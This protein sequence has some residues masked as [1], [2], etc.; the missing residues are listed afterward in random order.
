MVGIGQHDDIGQLRILS[1]CTATVVRGICIRDMMPSCM[2][3]P[4]EEANRIQRDP[5]LDRLRIRRDDRFA[6]GH[7]ERA[8][9]KSEILHRRDHGK[10]IERAKRGQEG[11][12]HAV[13]RAPP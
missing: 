13:L 1:R 7:A 2:R 8:A 12:L 6:G 5:Q 10:A 9:H 4:P 11:V 3:A